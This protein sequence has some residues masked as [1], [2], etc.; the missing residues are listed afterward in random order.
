MRVIEIDGANRWPEWTNETLVVEGTDDPVFVRPVLRTKDDDVR[1]HWVDFR[2]GAL[3][4]TGAK[5]CDYAC[6]Y[7]KEKADQLRADAAQAE[8]AGGT[9]QFVIHPGKTSRRTTLTPAEARQVAL[10]IDEALRLLDDLPADKQP[11]AVGEEYFESKATGVE[12]ESEVSPPAD[13]LEPEPWDP[14]KIRIHTKHYSLRQLVDMI[15]DGDID[16]TPDF[17]RHYVW[18]ASQR[19][20]LIESLLLGIPLPSFYFNEN[21]EGKLQ[22]VD[23]VQR[24]TTIFKYVHQK[25]FK[26]GP[27]IYLRDLK[28][29]GFDDLAAM[30][31]RRLNSAQFV[32]HVI[33]PQTPYRVKFDIFR[34]INTHGTPLSAQEIRHCMSGARSRAFLRALANDESFLTATGDALKGHLRM[35]DLEVALRFVG[36][37]L[38]TPDEYA[39]YG[40]F[41]EFLGVVTRRLDDDLTDQSLDQLRADFVRGMTNCYA[42]FGN[43]AFRKWP[44]D[45]DWRNPINRGLFESW[46][47]V[48]ADHDETTVRAGSAELVKRAREMMTNDSEFIG[49]I[50]GSTGD[51]RNVRT[52][53]STVREA[54]QEV[55]G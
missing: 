46:G 3:G 37:R 23:G 30:F 29:Q 39:Q 21:A 25:S 22:V 49:S 19:W 6:A 40:S 34:R 38:F 47:T 52:R 8:S 48:L 44:W 35:A 9:V 41:D 24:L 20:S 43:Y 1:S 15:A 33:D 26:L 55:L 28:G 5:Y 17:Q 2:I 13:E 27:V 14:E 32:A 12:K 54:V 51:V 50:S 36:F 7:A 16:L 10:A 11:T 42:V 18:K 4:D 31:R 45:T 53:L